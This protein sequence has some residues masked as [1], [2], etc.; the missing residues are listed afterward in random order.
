ME[1]DALKIRHTINIAI[2]F[3][4]FEFGKV[5]T[6]IQMSSRESTDSVIHVRNRKR[7]FI[8][9]ETESEDD[10]TLYTTDTRIYTLNIL[11]H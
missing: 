3:E 7:C 4:H 8:L 5:V 6:V 10:S 2:E 1:N 9:S 11:M